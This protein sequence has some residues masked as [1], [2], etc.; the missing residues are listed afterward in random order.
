MKSTSRNWL[1]ALD[2]LCL[3]NNKIIRLE[4][5]SDLHLM[6]GAALSITFMLV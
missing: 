4:H 5:L 2:R 6:L 1:L 3:S